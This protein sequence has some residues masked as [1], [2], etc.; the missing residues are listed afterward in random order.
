MPVARLWISTCS[1]PTLRV[2]S[3][4]SVSVVTTRILVAWAGLA[5]SVLARLHRHAVRVFD[6]GGE[7]VDLNMLA[8]DVAC[9]VGQV[10]ERGDDADSGCVGRA[11]AKRDGGND[12]Q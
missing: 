8:A 7:T 2:R 12:D 11:G 9:E 6:A 3:A 4:R 1:P 5:P 10:G